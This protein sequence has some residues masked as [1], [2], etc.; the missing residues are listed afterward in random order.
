M[1]WRV[2]ALYPFLF[3]AVYVLYLAWQSPGYYAIGDL[4]L[5]VF[6]ITAWIALVYLLA[7]TFGSRA[8]G[9][10]PALI[11]FLA[12][13]IALG[14]SPLLTQLRGL[15]RGMRLIAT[16]LVSFVGMALTV[17]WLARR[18]SLLRSAATL[19]TLTGT[20]LLVRFGLAIALARHDASEEV[21]KSGLAHTLARPIAGPRQVPGPRRDI[22]L[23]VLDEYANDAV[24][25]DRFRFDNRPFEDS[26]RA[27]G[28]Y[29]PHVVSSNYVHTILSLPSLLNAAH[30][31]ALESELSDHVRDPTLV[32]SLL[33]WNRVAAFLRGRDYEYVFFPSLWWY[34]TH[35]SRLADSVVN[36]W[37]GFDLAHALSRTE[38]RR[39]IRQN[40]ILRFLHRNDPY[41]ADYIRRTLA[42]FEAVGARNRPVFAF[43][44]IV[45]P[46]WPFVFNRDCST[47]SASADT[48]RGNAAYIEQVQCLNSLV[49]ETVHRILRRSTVPP[50]ILLQGD[51]GTSTLEYSDAPTAAQVDPAAARERFGAFGAYYLPDSGAAAFGDTVTVVNVLGNV[52]RHYF[53]AELPPEADD[54]FMSLERTPFVFS[55]AGDPSRSSTSLERTPRASHPEESGSVPTAPRPP[56]LRRSS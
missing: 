48:L 35:G 52:L 55:R 24:L 25:K 3:G 17:R 28:F 10:L 8:E 14:F 19:L 51:H 22:Y 39:T 30:L 20:L 7:T 9:R 47:P 32:N 11:A 33:E 34:S 23:L 41:D 15:P 49:L 40:T 27:L 42:G 2:T 1:A 18:P 56:R 5:I 6:A 43:A 46:H 36:V 21:E 45:S 26:L 4:L 13:V 53:G 16:A 50:V 29:I 44:H 12:L 54:R 37:P 31:Y 38:L